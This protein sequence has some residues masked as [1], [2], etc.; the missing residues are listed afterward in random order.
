[1]TRWNRW[2]D[3]G[4]VAAGAYALVSPIWTT[5]T[6]DATT[7][8][9]VLGAVTA[10]IALYALYAPGVMATE[11]AIMLMGVLMFLSPWVIGFDSVT[12]MAWTAWIVGAVTFALGL[13][14]FM[15]GRSAH[16]HGP[17]AQH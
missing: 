9:I 15:E 13:A 10:L 7:T 16:H 17:I 5:T 12:G 4:A 3:W 11:A 8:A 1:M 14:D 6:D 2:Q